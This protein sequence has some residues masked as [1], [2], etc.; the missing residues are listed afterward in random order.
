GPAPRPAAAG[1]TARIR[2]PRTRPSVRRPRRRA[3]CRR[4]RHREPTMP[5]PRLRAPRATPP[6]RAALLCA[7]MLLLALATALA[8][9]TALAQFNGNT[10]NDLLSDEGAD[11]QRV[12]DNNRSSAAAAA[13]GTALPG[14]VTQLRQPMRNTSGA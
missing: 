5:I 2:P 9:A 11:V 6:S 12:N 8:P 3:A 4:R 14:G 13:N 10:G 7:G 1:R